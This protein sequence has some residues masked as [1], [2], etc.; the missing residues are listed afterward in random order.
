MQ[1]AETPSR[2]AAHSE[3]LLTLHISK[4][5]GWVGL[6]GLAILCALIAADIRSRN[7]RQI[8]SVQNI[9]EERKSA[10]VATSD[11]N[12]EKANVTPLIGES[13]LVTTIKSQSSENYTDRKSAVA[14]ST[15]N[16]PIT[17]SEQQALLAPTIGARVGFAVARTAEEGKFNGAGTSFPHSIYSKWFSEYHK[18]HPEVQ[19]TYDAIGSG[20]GIRRMLD[21]TIDFG[22]TDVPMSDEQLSQAPIEILHVPTVLGAVVPIYNVP[23]AGELRFTPEVLAGMFLGKIVSWNDAAIARVNPAVN[24]PNR[25][26]MV[27]H[28]SDGSS[29][30]FTFTDYL[31]KVSADWQDSVGKGSSVKWPVGLGGKSNEGVAGMVRQ[32]EGAIGYIDLLYAEQSHSPFG[33]VR[34]RAGNFMRANLD[35]VTEAAA[36]SREMP[37]DFRVSITNAPGNNA[38]P[39]ASFTWFLVPQEFA[40]PTRGKDLALFL[41]WMIADGQAMTKDL[42]YAP[43]PKNVAVRISQK[44]A[45]IP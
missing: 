27:I 15:L 7:S 41:R 16:P 8:P 32:I 28:R 20:G 22:G 17:K 14:F 1:N 23:G 24:L 33:R 45:Q 30:T 34:N 25:P 42:G 39:I 10:A 21:G 26:I 40:D 36:S 29:T 6:L 2:L 5:A 43:L 31:S 35:N 3:A 18:L 12:T 37:A 19:F 9:V 38:Y 13:N 4:R 44:I 11:G